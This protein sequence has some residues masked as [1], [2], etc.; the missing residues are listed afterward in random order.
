MYC[1]LNI[2]QFAV[3][4]TQFVEHLLPQT[5]LVPHNDE[6]LTAFPGC[7]SIPAQQKMAEHLSFALKICLSIPHITDDMGVSKNR[8]TPIW[9]VYYG[10]PY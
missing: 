2:Q 1:I 6:D 7:I 10:K 3:I 4:T 9:M 5:S 8:G